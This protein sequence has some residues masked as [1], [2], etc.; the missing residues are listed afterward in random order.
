M[1]TK[2]YKEIHKISLREASIINNYL[3]A[4]EGD[5]HLSEDE[6]ITHTVYFPDGCQIDIKC[7]GTG[8]GPAFAEAVLFDKSGG[9]MAYSE[10]EDEYLGTWTLEYNGT[11]YTV[12][13]DVIGGGG[14]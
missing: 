7:C 4:S 2:S 3:S 9:Q 10:P 11:T 13:V 8:N 12:T 5:E 1:R 14:T 6:T